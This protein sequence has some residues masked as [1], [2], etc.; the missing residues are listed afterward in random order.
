MESVGSQKPREDRDLASHE[1]S[2]VHTDSLL[3]GSVVSLGKG[4]GC[5]PEE[6]QTESADDCILKCQV[7]SVEGRLCPPGPPV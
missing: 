6:G 2:V 4:F 5:G 1:W 7:W 3:R